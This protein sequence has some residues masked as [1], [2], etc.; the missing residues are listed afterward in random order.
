MGSIEDD[1]VGFDTDTLHRQRGKGIAVGLLG[2]GER[3]SL[4][5]GKLNIESQQGGG[6]HVHFEIPWQEGHGEK[7]SGSHS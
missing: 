6:T 5:G 7:N 2:M 1:G 3:I 4:L